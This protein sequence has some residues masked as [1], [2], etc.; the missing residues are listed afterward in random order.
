[1]CKI[2]RASIR[3][4]IYLTPTG[5]VRSRVRVDQDGEVTTG[6]RVHA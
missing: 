2:T 1:M 6:F 4:G 3:H 5:E